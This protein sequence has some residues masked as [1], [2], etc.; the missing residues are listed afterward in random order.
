[1]NRTELVIK[2]FNPNEDG[3]SRW[4]SKEECVGE[5][6]SLYPTNGNTWYRNQGIKKYKLEIDKSKYGTRWRF[7]GF[8]N[9]KSPRSIKSEI[10]K[11]IRNKPCVV[12]GLKLKNGHKIEVD[13]KDGRYPQEVLDFETQKNEDF[14]PL[15]ESLNKQKRSDCGKCKKTGIRFDAR[16][17]GFT[18]SVTEGTLNYDGTC[19]GCYWFDVKNFISKLN[20]K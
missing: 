19:V 7:N 5:F 9:D 4:V 20:V 8:S 17:K 1:M 3:I 16:E 18:V 15:L 13:H 10:W 6:I 11:D 14:Q 12:T 2:L